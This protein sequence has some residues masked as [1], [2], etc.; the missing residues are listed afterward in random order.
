MYSLLPEKLLIIIHI[1]TASI[2]ERS[3][4][5]FGALIYSCSLDAGM[6]LQI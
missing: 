3:D 1:L 6:G 4:V 5:E 2:I